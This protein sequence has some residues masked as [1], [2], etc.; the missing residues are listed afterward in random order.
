MSC[1]H[2]GAGFS[3]LMEYIGHKKLCV[4]DEQFGFST[5]QTPPTPQQP[6]T[7][8]KKKSPEVSDLGRDSTKIS[9]PETQISSDSQPAEKPAN[10]QEKT[11]SS[12]SHMR[13]ESENQQ[14]FEGFICDSCQTQ[15]SS[16]VQYEKH[17]SICLHSKTR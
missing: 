13:N 5:D 8:K 9:P 16:M 2:C 14:S 11:T 1:G 15:F 7:E 3:T 4:P 17:R 6:S 10:I 12:L